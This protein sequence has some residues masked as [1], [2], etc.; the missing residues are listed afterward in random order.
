MGVWYC[1]REAVKGALDIKL[2]ARAD[3]LVDDA[4]EA[5]ARAIE[6]RLH[7]EFY[8]QMATRFFDWPSENRGSSWRLWLDGDQLLDVTTLTAAGVVIP[9]GDYFLEPANAGPPYNR[10]EIDLAGASSFSAGATRQRAIEILGLWGSA[11]GTTDEA[12]AGAL[13]E[14]LD[15]VE[16]DVDVNGAAAAAVGVGTILRCEAERMIVTG[17][18]MMDTGVN[19]TG[20]LT[21]AVASDTSGTVADGTAFTVGEEIVVGAERMLIVDIPGNT[22]VVKRAWNGST[23]ATH[24]TDDI[25][26]SR[27]LTVERGAL[28]TTAAAHNTATALRRHKVPGLIFSLNKAEAINILQ[29]DE[30]A[31]GRV[32]GQ[33]EGQ[34][35]AAGKGLASLWEQAVAAYGRK[36]RVGS[37]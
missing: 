13:T 37:T 6:G 36:L 22:L 2:T 34:R 1:T 25:F 17:R 3:A 14:A 4:V 7:R 29:Q 21:T 33:G 9:S 30:A 10:V 23:L 19:L 11:G 26:A 12:A 18:T 8:P 32:V 24:G 15:D 16:T 27:R 5:G 35:E 28:G 20:G 31:W